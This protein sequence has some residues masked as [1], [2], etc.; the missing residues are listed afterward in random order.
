M[1]EV[2]GNKI[3]LV[4][5][6][7]FQC[8]G[9][10][11]G[12]D[13]KTCPKYELFEDY[14]ENPK[15]FHCKNWRPSTF[16]GGVG[17]LCLGL[18]KGFLR[19]GMVEFHDKPFTY[20]RLYET[21]ENRPEYDRFNIPVWAMEKDGYLYVR[22]FSPRNCWIFVDVIKDGK[23]EMASF[24]NGKYEHQAINVGEFFDEID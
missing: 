12:T 22:C 15:L 18:P 17:R 3:Q 20:L 10:I 1:I 4:M 13:P 14:N 5:V 23:I 21:P 16:M 6:K 2:K 19:T 11:N 9:C 24:K 7:E 8:P